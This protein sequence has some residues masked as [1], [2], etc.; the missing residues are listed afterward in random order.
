VGSISRAPS[1]IVSAL[2]GATGKLIG[3][4][5]PYPLWSDLSPAAFIG[6]KRLSEEDFD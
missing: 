6:Q 5:I 2:A 3:R 4:A 1:L